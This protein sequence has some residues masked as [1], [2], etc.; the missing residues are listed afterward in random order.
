MICP[1]QGFTF[2]KSYL[3][4]LT[5]LSK[6][7]SG[8]SFRYSLGSSKFKPLEYVFTNLTRLPRFGAK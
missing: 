2:D 1:E 7:L 6:S 5:S 8:L 3:S 4:F